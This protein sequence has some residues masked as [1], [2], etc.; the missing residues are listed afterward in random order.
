[1]GTSPQEFRDQYYNRCKWI[2]DLF[3]YGYDFL[4]GRFSRR[5]EID[6]ESLWDAEEEKIKSYD[7]ENEIR[8]EDGELPESVRQYLDM[9]GDDEQMQT[10][11][12]YIRLF[13]VLSAIDHAAAGLNYLGTCVQ[14]RPGWWPN[15]ID[16]FER[17][18]KELQQ[19]AAG[20]VIFKPRYFQRSPAQD[21]L[22]HALTDTHKWREISPR[23]ENLDSYFQNLLRICGPQ[24]CKFTF[25]ILSATQDFHQPTWKKFQIGIVPLIEELKVRELD[26]QLLPGPLVI[27]K[28]PTNGSTFGIHVEGDPTESCAELCVRAEAG[29]RYLAEKGCQVV[30]FPEMVMPD[31]VVEHLKKVLRQLA[32]QKLPRPGLILA[33]TFTRAA[34]QHTQSQP[35]NVAVVLNHCGEEL[36]TQRKMQP[37]EMKL[38]EQQRFGLYPILRGEPCLEHIAVSNRELH[39]VDSRATGLRMSVLICEDATRAPGLGAISE[40][41][42]TLILAPVMAGPLESSCGFGDS[43]ARALSETAGI[44]VVANSAALARA[45]WGT[46]DGHPPL[47]IVGLP[48]LNVHKDYRPLETLQHLERTPGSPSVEVLYYEFPTERQTF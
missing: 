10:P 13:S 22:D 12:F 37:Y 21:W 25:R 40:V 6:L 26:A 27:R 19:R 5:S 39:V 38:H 36:W 23:G 20:K 28:L 7:F 11:A 18:G 3:A 35:F 17:H 33:G 48:L 44:F 4:N 29:L 47:G 41:Q 15:T 32:A 42:A 34:P 45:A 16:Y 30:L 14:Y 24:G 9:P 2:F 46:K 43:V 8:N 1:M 31:P